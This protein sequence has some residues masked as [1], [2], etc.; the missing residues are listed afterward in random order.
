MNDEQTTNEELQLFDQGTPMVT[1]LT[2]SWALLMVPGHLKLNKCT[3]NE[4]RC[5]LS[6]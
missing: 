4:V 3:M 5:S 6:I 1:H 2:L